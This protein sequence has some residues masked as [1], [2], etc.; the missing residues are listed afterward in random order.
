MDILDYMVS[1]T[2]H[3]CGRGRTCSWRQSLVQT[4]SSCLLSLPWPGSEKRVRNISCVMRDLYVSGTRL[5]L[6]SCSIVRTLFL[7]QKR[8]RGKVTFFI[9]LSLIYSVSQLWRYFLGPYT[10]TTKE[11]R[12]TS[13]E[14]VIMCNASITI[15][16]SKFVGRSLVTHAVT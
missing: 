16:S 13:S 2:N 5:F 8:R 4:T 9:N 14:L 11:G 3:D 15:L 12:N 10:A 6:V 7:W 1:S